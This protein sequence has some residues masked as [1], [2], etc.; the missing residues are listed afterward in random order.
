MALILVPHF[1]PLLSCSQSI[2][3]RFQQMLDLVPQLADA[4]LLPTHLHGS[5]LPAADY[6]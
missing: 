5:Q 2:P 6:E 1:F 4:S 3:L